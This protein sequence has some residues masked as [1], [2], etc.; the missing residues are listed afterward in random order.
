MTHPWHDVKP[1]RVTPQQFL[2]LIEIS[3]GSKINTN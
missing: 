3:K 1:N 2:A